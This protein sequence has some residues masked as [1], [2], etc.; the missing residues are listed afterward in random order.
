MAT[1]NH[2]HAALST[3]AK[4]RK[5]LEGHRLAGKLEPVAGAIDQLRDS[6]EALST[7]KNNPSPDF[8]KSAWA[9][10]FALHRNR[11]IEASRRTTERL[12][13]ELDSLER[14]LR[15]TAE[16][17][18]GL[19]A[20]LDPAAAAEIRAA[21]RAMSQEQRDAAITKAA[22]NRDVAVLRAVREAPSALLVGD[23]NAPV[24]ALIEQLIHEANP[25]L[26]HDLAAIEDAT[27]RLSMAVDGFLSETQ[28][29][30]DVSAE[31]QA[32]AQAEAARQAEAKLAM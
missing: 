9:A 3:A 29:L 14:E 32:A 4:L 26:E 11:A 27:T 28:K 30:R 17:N 20:P 25:G 13:G 15:T 22:Q 31:E 2:T 10:R 19:H 8:T 7:L 24:D 23:L 12:A 6:F 1:S 18:A 16:R 21:L 5:N